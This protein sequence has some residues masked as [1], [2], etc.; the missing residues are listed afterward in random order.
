MWGIF[1]DAIGCIQSAA[2]FYV[3]SVAMDDGDHDLH[4]SLSK[5]HQ[6]AYKERG[7]KTEGRRLGSN[8]G[9]SE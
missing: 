2:M 6:N 9:G 8:T 3:V 7:A 5:K 4:G 1:R